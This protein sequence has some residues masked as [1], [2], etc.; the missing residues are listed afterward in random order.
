MV[1]V[2]AALVAVKGESVDS[3]V[4][5]ISSSSVIVDCSPSVDVSTVEPISLV[6][7]VEVVRIVL[8]VVVGTMIHEFK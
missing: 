4:D 2:V 5:R 3:V 8:S 7:V 1:V 6:L